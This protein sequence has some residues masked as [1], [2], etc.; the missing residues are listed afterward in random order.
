MDR[1]EIL[2]E[3]PSMEA[4][5]KV[6][7]PS[8]LSGGWK[9]NENVFVRP[10]QG[11]GDLKN[12]IPKKFK[13]FSKDS[14]QITGFII[15]QDQDANDCKQLKNE[16][17]QLCKQNNFGNRC[18]YKVRIVCHELEAWYLGDPD[19]ISLIFPHDFKAD[20]YRNKSICK[21]PDG[22]VSPKK[23]LK[24][25]V[26]DYPQIQTAT[27]IAGKMVVGANQSKSFKQF[28]GA[29]DFLTNRKG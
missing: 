1:L 3:E 20:S 7:L 6:I 28:V 4:L 26:G 8:I 22:I 24:R 13:A 27:D 19:A 23:Q 25:I 18:P 17:D 9:L 21:A 10:H 2:V 15:L 5:L 12:S 16:L 14:S 29:V 11:K